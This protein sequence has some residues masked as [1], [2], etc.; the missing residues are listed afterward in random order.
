MRKFGIEIETCLIVEY[1]S[2][3]LWI[4]YVEVYL[5]Q[6]FENWKS[7]KELLLYTQNF[8]NKIIIKTEKY[9]ID[10]DF[11]IFDLITNSLSLSSEIYEID[12]NYPTIA[13][14]YSVVCHDYAH[15]F[16]N[17]AVHPTVENQN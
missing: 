17:H 7:D 12:Y 5:K 10:A 4:N 6:V 16:I 13:P 2:E 9:D 1:H 14:D 11:L 15:G 8:D 3:F